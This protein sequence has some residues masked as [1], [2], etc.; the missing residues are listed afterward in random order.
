MDQTLVFLMVLFLVMA[1]SGATSAK[2]AT[3]DADI[4]PKTRR[5][6]RVTGILILGSSLLGAAIVAYRLLPQQ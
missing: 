5:M 2:K 1:L 6:L 3:P 4:S